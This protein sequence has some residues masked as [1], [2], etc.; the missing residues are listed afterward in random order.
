M[1]AINSGNTQMF[2]HLDRFCGIT[3]QKGGVGGGGTGRRGYEW[4]KGYVERG[5]K[6]RGI[7]GNEC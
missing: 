5:W 6:G 1:V 7:K 4:G 2:Q 3:K